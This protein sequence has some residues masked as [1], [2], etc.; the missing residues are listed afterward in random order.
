MRQ[1]SN[2]ALARIAEL[3]RAAAAGLAATGVDLG[4]LA[5]L[6]SGCALHPRLASI[7]ALVAGGFANFIGNRHFAFRAQQGSMTLQALGYTAVELVALAL[8]GVLYDAVLRAFPITVGA[9]WLVRLA[10]SHLVFLAWSFPLW[11]KVFT[12]RPQPARR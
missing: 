12:V 8:N 4:V 11:R 6:V 5:L 2:L 1:R 7:P 3:L 10:T 9:Y